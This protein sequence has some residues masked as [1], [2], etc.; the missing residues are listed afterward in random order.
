MKKFVGFYY[1]CRLKVCLCACL[2]LIGFLF[3][4]SS[5][6]AAQYGD[7][8]YSV[9]NGTVIINEYI[10]AGGDVV[11]PPT[12]NGMPVVAIWYNIDYFEGYYY[13]AFEDCTRLT[14]V[15]IPDSVTRIGSY[16]F[17]GCSG[18]TSVTIPDSVTSIDQYAFEGC[19]GLTS[20]TIGNSV[21]SIGDYAF[22]G[23]TG[24]TSV[25]I[26]NSVTS[27]GR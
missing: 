19:S 21:T 25:T 18:L 1:R 5:A 27:I 17:E 15:V 12:I 6:F 23:C 11:I 14:S 9:S 4:S 16:A 10:G 3:L 24:I 8:V 22:D 2:S 7:Y 13:G 20:M 26:G